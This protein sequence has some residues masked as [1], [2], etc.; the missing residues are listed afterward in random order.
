MSYYY[1]TVTRK[2]IRYK[3]V[4]KSYTTEQ[5][6]KYEFLFEIIKLNQQIK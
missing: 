4:Y 6:K 1:S 5:D 2:L 3:T